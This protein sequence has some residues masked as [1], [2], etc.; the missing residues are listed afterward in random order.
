M[1]LM[2]AC[3]RLGWLLLGLVQEVGAAAFCV[4]PAR[5]RVTPA[6]GETG[7]HMLTVVN[8]SADSTRFKVCLEDWTMTE[9]GRDTTLEPGTLAN[10]C[11]PWLAVNPQEF[12]VRAGEPAEVR[13]TFSPPKEAAGGYWCRL[14]IESAPIP[15]TWSST[16][17]VNAQIAVPVFADVAGTEQPDFDLS[18]L[19]C[20]QEDSLVLSGGVAN[21]GN[22]PLNLTGRV[23]IEQAGKTVWKGT[24][25]VGFL[26]PGCESEFTRRLGVKL[27]PGEYLARLTIEHPGR[28]EDIGLERVF[29]V[30]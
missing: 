18:Y 25:D 29:E 20:R 5:L 8:S 7:T 4:S 15:A 6:P 17:H 21:T 26:L 11:A 27:G 28:E 13:L 10:S 23:V 12:W 16:I 14:C 30:E 3:P 9:S 22:V 1:K 24:T 2:R 19:E